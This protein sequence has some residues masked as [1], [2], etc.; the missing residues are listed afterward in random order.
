MKKI[1]ASGL[2]I[3]VLSFLTSCS[4]FGKKEEKKEAPAASMAIE[5]AKKL[6]KSLK[7]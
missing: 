5:F 2:V 3:I 7:K 1:V 4:F 6:K